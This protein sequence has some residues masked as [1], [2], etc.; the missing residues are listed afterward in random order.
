[1]WSD[2]IQK[3]STMTSDTTFRFNQNHKGA[4]KR[5][6]RN[7]KIFSHTFFKHSFITVTVHQPPKH[8][9]NKRFYVNCFMATTTKKYLFLFPVFWQNLLVSQCCSA[10]QYHHIPVS[11]L[12]FHLWFIVCLSVFLLNTDTSLHSIMHST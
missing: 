1:M 8:Y 4:D 11:W 5:G 9:I 12:T 3:K 10:K 7:A 6:V 2:L